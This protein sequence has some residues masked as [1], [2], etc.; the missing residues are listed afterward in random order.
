[1]DHRDVDVA[2]QL[3]GLGDDL[4]LQLVEVILVG[5]AGQPDDGGDNGEQVHGDRKQCSRRVQ[6][7]VAGNLVN[8][9]RVGMNSREISGGKQSASL[10]PAQE[11]EGCCV[12][13]D[14]CRKV[15][16]REAV[17]SCSLKFVGCSCSQGTITKL[18]CLN[19][20]KFVL[21]R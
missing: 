17:L 10:A 5:G 20:Q 2:L 6:S 16:V 14:V 3:H 8:G 21:W 7:R 12:L 9:N 13:R 18:H 1:M 4:G 15:A 11:D 19:R